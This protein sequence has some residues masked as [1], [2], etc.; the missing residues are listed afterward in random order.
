MFYVND[1]PEGKFLYTDSITLYCI[2]IQE[3]EE[4]TICLGLLLLLLSLLLLLLLLL[5]LFF[6][7]VFV[8][9][10]V[11]GP[12]PSYKQKHRR[13]RIIRRPSVG[14]PVGK[15]SSAGCKFVT[16]SQLYFHAS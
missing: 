10:F 5:L 2:A 11:V 15:T 4:G 3:N 7:F 8:C 9:L 6:V 16:S 14:R 12:L 13:R 1:K